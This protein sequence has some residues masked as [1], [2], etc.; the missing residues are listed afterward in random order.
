MLELRS[1][2]HVR[3]HCHPDFLL[4]PKVALVSPPPE[5]LWCFAPNFLPYFFTEHLT[6]GLPCPGLPLPR[7]SAA[8]GIICLVRDYALLILAG[9]SLA[10]Q[11]DKG[12]G[13]E[14][15]AC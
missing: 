13:S 12:K 2:L 14:W 10:L 7:V 15:I 9:Q 8:L 11:I 3:S 5:R 6:L 1:P 4:H